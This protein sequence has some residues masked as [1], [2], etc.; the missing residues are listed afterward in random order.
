MN[1]CTWKR[2][3]RV[4]PS[5]VFPCM[6]L[7]HFLESELSKVKETSSPPLACFWLPLKWYLTPSDLFCCKFYNFLSHLSW[8]NAGGIQESLANISA[9]LCSPVEKYSS[10]VEGEDKK[11]SGKCQIF[12][13]EIRISTMKYFHT[14]LILCEGCEKAQLWF[15]GKCQQ[16]L[17]P[18]TPQICLVTKLAAGFCLLILPCPEEHNVQFMA[19]VSNYPQTSLALGLRKHVLHLRACWDFKPIT[20]AWTGQWGHSWGRKVLEEPP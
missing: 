15:P 20:P 5:S 7:V 10:G 2:Q 17:L 1:L 11:F 6:I 4:Q 18:V 19:P 3:L 12:Q 8:K 9:N 14:A 16:F 13:R